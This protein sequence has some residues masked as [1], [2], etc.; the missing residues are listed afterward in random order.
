M[1]PIKKLVVEDLETHINELKT[2]LTA[3]RKKLKS[4]MSSEIKPKSK[5]K[6]TLNKK[7]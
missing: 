5:P 6:P 3:V 2:A 7:K 4:E 1:E